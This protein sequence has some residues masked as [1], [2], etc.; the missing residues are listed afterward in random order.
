[1]SIFRNLPDRLYKIGSAA[2]NATILLGP[3]TATLGLVYHC[4]HKMRSRYYE[5]FYN[6]LWE[7]IMSPI[8]FDGSAIVNLPSNNNG[9]I[10]VA[11]WQGIDD[12]TPPVIK[13]C[14]DSIKRHAG[15]REVI[16]VTKDNYTQY[17]D[18]DPVLVE[19]RR[20][21]TLTINAFCNALRVR[22]LYLHGGVWLDST[23]YLTSDLSSD[24]EKYLFYSINAGDKEY[25]WTTYCLASVPGNPFMD[26][27]YRCF[28]KVFRKIPAVPEYFLF[29]AFIM[30]A[31]RHIPEVRAMVESVPINN[32]DS[33]ELA[34]CLDSTTG[35][36]RL[37]PNTYI[38]KLT[39]KINYPTVKAGKPTLYQAILDGKL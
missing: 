18:I 1:M 22:L 33:L 16:I 38:N 25:H 29:D 23:L 20:R 8:P 21:G 15:G 6:T 19:R 12:N 37:N 26:Y 14:I 39:Y 30:N 32:T 27:I 34:K 35:D 10:W 11:W 2:K 4:T 24:F 36:D 5:M 3:E 7:K 13:A 31:Y 17:V 9:P 28:C